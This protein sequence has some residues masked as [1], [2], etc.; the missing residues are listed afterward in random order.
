MNLVGFYGNALIIN[1]LI[2][3]T[4][5]E[6]IF[7]LI[8]FIYLPANSISYGSSIFYIAYYVALLLILEGLS[9][10]SDVYTTSS[11]SFLVEVFEWLFP[12]LVPN[13]VSNTSLNG[14]YCTSN[15]SLV[16]VDCLLY[17]LILESFLLIC[18]ELK[19]LTS[20]CALN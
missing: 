19:V 6:L 16:F 9:F 18:N 15:F 13:N 14:F 10:Q 7:L 17:E 5:L 1:S 3:L 11:F 2:F 4:M 8:T 20:E 12:M